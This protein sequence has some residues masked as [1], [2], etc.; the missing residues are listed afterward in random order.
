MTDQYVYLAL[1]R[2]PGPSELHTK[3]RVTASSLGEAKEHLEQEHG[4]GSVISLWNETKADAPR[5]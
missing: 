2:L 4:K 5:A 1:V 3:V